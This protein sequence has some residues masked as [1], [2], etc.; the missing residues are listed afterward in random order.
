LS[1]LSWCDMVK[2]IVF[3]QMLHPCFLLY[4]VHASHLNDTSCV[5]SSH[6]SEHISN[7]IQYTSNVFLP[8]VLSCG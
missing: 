2:L 1:Q 6:N 4:N 8:C 5:L 7:H 3:M